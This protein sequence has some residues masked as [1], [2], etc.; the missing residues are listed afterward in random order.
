MRDHRQLG[1]VQARALSFLADNQAANGA[2]ATFFSATT[3]PFKE[4]APYYTTFLPALILHALAKVNGSEEI[5]ARLAEWLIAQRGSEWSFNYWPTD[6]AERGEM[7]YPD[8]LDDT[9]CVLSALWQHDHKLISPQVMGKAVR[10]LLATETEVGGPYRTWIV[11]PTAE[12]IWL[13]TDIA[14]NANVAYFLRL[15]AQS[16][17]N[18][19]TQMERAITSKKFTSPYYPS[20][21]PILYYIGR[22]YHGPKSGALVRYIQSLQTEDGHWDSP[23]HTALAMCILHEQGVAFDSHPAISYLLETQQTDGSWPAEPFW[24][25]VKQTY[26]GSAALTTALIL[27]ALE[28]SAAPALEVSTAT[29]AKAT[30][31]Q[32]ASIYRAVMSRAEKVNRTLPPGLH[33][34]AEATL[35]RMNR[36]STNREVVLLPYFFAV[37]QKKSAAAAASELL[38]ALGLANMHG[39][40]AY[41][42][43]DD[44]LD[45]GGDIRALPLANA[46]MRL[47]LEEFV[48]AVPKSPSYHA[49]V[50][51]TF[52][53]IDSANAWEAR[54]C[55]FVVSGHSVHIA[56]VPNFG[57]LE[58]LAER[59][60]GHALP[61]L[62]I[63]AS[64]NIPPN[65]SDARLL[66]RALKHYLIARQLGDD[67]QDWEMDIRSGQCSAV[68]AH[69][70]SSLHVRPGTHR[71]E[72]VINQMR[73]ALASATA[74]EISQI[75]LD[76]TAHSSH[77]L[78]KSGLVR[79]NSQIS[80]LN[81]DIAAIARQQLQ[82][83]QSAR[84]FLTAYSGK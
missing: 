77:H 13:D 7:P 26:S 81:D 23:M 58:Q 10:I 37:S 15:T 36:S 49:F 9:F 16:L 46:F 50:R 57:N 33:A 83:Y 21:W 72:A 60:L 32:A 75:I 25:E 52:N 8:D 74:E 67:M 30:D 79:P 48:Q 24:L 84:E 70:L 41:T 55:K 78:R 61:A 29:T 18:L 68:V 73:Q 44:V 47:S 63:L 42:I 11:P 80:Q 35:A 38:Q 19:D 62:A 2:F 40:A 3:R 56:S 5:R 6:A 53:R 76:Q 39:W 66:L 69:L 1:V 22:A 65:S 28:L 71:L 64:Q 4:R 45:G 54:N 14:V 27:E 59:S 51:E 82:E 43:Y 17:P 12:K 31:S 20:F 34:S